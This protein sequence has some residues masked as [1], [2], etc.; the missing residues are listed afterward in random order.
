[1]HGARLVSRDLNK[2]WATVIPTSFQVLKPPGNTRVTVTLQVIH[3]G[4]K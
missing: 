2:P 1:M 4:R 3:T